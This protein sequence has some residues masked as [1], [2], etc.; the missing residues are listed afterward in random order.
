M[1]QDAG[2]T[3]EKVVFTFDNIKLTFVE[4]ISLPF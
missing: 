2:I 1:L 3:N 4:T